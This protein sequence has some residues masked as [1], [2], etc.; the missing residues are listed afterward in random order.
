MATSYIFDIPG[1]TALK[2]EIGN[3]DIAGFES[4]FYVDLSDLPHFADAMY[5]ANGD[6]FELTFTRY[7]QD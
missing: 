7:I 3:N 4:E 2:S 6:D 5:N 1:T